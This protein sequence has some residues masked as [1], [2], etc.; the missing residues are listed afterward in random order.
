[1]GRRGGLVLKLPR[2]RVA[3]LVACGEG[4][5]FTAGRGRPMKEWVVLD[6]RAEKLWLA[7][8]TEALDFV[9]GRSMTE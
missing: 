6:E 9:A 2:A 1:M 8:A 4:V 3:E 7:L 5:P